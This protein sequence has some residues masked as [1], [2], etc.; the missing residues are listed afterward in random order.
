MRPLFS[1]FA[2][3]CFLLPFSSAAVPEGWHESYSEALAQARSRNRPLVLLFTGSD[4]CSSC[5]ELERNVLSDPAF[6]SFLLENF[7]P[8]YLDFP[9][10]PMK[11][12]AENETVLRRFLGEKFTF[13]TAVVLSPEEKKLGQFTGKADQETYRRILSSLAKPPRVLHSVVTGSAADVQLLLAGGADPN[14]AD[15]SGVTPLMRAA[16]DGDAG[17]VQV[18]LQGGAGKEKKDSEGL[19]ALIYAIRARQHKTLDLL[20]LAG[21]DVNAVTVQGET[22]LY[23]AIAAGAAES[24]RRLVRAGANVNQGV[25]TYAIPPAGIAILLEQRAIAL[26]LLSSGADLRAQD[27]SGSSLM[28]YAVSLGDQRMVRLLLE[29]NAPAALRDADGRIPA[30][31]TADPALRKLLNPAKK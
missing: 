9:R 2:A 29:R 17:K 10:R 19:T 22:P 18:L 1:V 23:F 24:V 3:V 6:Q 5:G 13:P 7:I 21:A 27:R 14:E 28:H 8:V 12:A 30:D 16:S 11:N 20:L 26:L 15:W 4:W 31:F 25:G